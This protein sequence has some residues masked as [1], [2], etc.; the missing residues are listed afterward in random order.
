MDL[1]DLLAILT[2]I[3]VPIIIALVVLSPFI[4]LKV[5]KKKFTWKAIIICLII[6]IALIFL[7]RYLWFVFWNWAFDV[8][9]EAAFWSF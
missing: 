3:F 8:I 6:S 9:G 2:I 1:Y 7:F 5:R 4:F